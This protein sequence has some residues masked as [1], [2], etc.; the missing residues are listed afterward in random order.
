M[1][2]MSVIKICPYNYLPTTRL[3]G[4]LSPTSFRLAFLGSKDQ[5]RN[6]KM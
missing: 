1:Y 3:P 2:K 4:L 5:V 6:L